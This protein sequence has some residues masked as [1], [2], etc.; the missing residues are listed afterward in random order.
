MIKVALKVNRFSCFSSYL[1][2]LIEIFGNATK[3]TSGILKKSDA[4]SSTVDQPNRSI[5]AL[6]LLY[7]MT[8]DRNPQLASLVVPYSAVR[9]HQVASLWLPHP[10]PRPL[11]LVASCPISRCC[12]CHRSLPG[13][14]RPGAGFF[15]CTSR[16]LPSSDVA[17]V[18]FKCF[19]C[20]ICMLQVFSCGCC[21]SKSGRWLYTYIASVCSKCFSCF[22]WMLHVFYLGVAYVS[23]CY[24]YFIRM[25]HM[26][27]NICWKCF[28]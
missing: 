23:L 24:K 25:L 22:R 9:P 6:S 1:Q 2:F 11:R 27:S 4:R 5:Y 26:F 7:N 19:R 14:A 15:G 10:E 28:I 20:F 18:C 3:Y 12:R 17:S 8:T 16:S 13:V 21:K